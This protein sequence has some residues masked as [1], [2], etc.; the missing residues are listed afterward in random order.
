M[1]NIADCL[2]RLVGR[3]VLGRDGRGGRVSPALWVEAVGATHEQIG[4]AGDCQNS[5]VILT[6]IL[7]GGKE[8]K[9]T[10]FIRSTT[11]ITTKIRHSKLISNR[12]VVMV[13]WSAC[14]PCS[15]TIRVR[16]P[17]KS[18]VFSVKFMF[19]ENENKKRPGLAHF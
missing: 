7:I 6:L 9:D 19:E 16:I 4:G 12:A 8:I 14:L 1:I 15:L 11:T 10:I 17:L 2:G 13:K 18:T 3:V 5:D